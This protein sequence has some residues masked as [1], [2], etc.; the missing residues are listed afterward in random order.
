LNASSAGELRSFE[1][2]IHSYQESFFRPNLTTILNLVQC[3]L[4]GQVDPGLTFDFVPLTE[5]LTDS[6]RAAAANQVIAAAT[7][8]FESGLLSRA[9]ALKTLRS[10]GEGLGLEGT[11]DDSMVDEA[12]NAPPEPSPEELR[13]E[14]EMVKAESAATH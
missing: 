7:N 3:S 6:E 11:I 9:D 1:E 4:F 14:A 12:E 5:E 8:A 10:L 2:N 13:A